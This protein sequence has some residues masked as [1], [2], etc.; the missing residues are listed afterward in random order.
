MNI[1]QNLLTELK[2]LTAFAMA[3]RDSFYECCSTRQGVV[4]DE[5]DQRE[6]KRI[7]TM[8]DSARTA[9]AQA[10]NETQKV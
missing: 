10:E 4:K 1:N 6:L 9:I 2:N 5:H 7:D 8:I 3:E